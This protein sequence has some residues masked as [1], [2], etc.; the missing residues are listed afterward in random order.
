MVFID[1]NFSVPVDLSFQKAPTTQ[2]TAFS[3]PETFAC[4]GSTNVTI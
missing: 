3:Y 1:M 2:V 4:R